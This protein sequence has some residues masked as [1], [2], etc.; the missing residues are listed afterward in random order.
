MR[1]PNTLQSPCECFAP[2]LGDWCKEACP[3]SQPTLLEKQQAP[4]TEREN[5]L[6]AP[7]TDRWVYENDEWTVSESKIDGVYEM[8][9]TVSGE[10]VATVNLPTRR[11]VLAAAREAYLA[12]SHDP[13]FTLAE[14]GEFVLNEA[15][16]R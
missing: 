2:F 5:E 12:A 7:L 6:K 10:V 9:H 15:V 13:L 16:A 8:V 1:D 3:Y 11:E 14:N 4:S